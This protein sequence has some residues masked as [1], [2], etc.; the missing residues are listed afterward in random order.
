M[1]EAK[2]KLG[3]TYGLRLTSLFILVGERSHR[4]SPVFP[5]H[6]LQH[7]LFFPQAFICIGLWQRERKVVL[8]EM[9]WPSN[10]ETN[11]WRKK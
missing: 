3:K 1:S 10:L 4:I 6:F 5:L 7:L 8:K 9:G 11:A 2:E